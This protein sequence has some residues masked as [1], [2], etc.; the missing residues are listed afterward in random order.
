MESKIREE[1]ERLTRRMEWKQEELDKAVQCFR[2]AAATYSD[3]D[4]ETFIPGKVEEIKRYR[5][6][7][8]EMAEQKQMLE[9][10]L[11]N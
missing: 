3:Y 2:E 1:I 4:I 10:L 7:M 9:Y 5:A 6:A 8:S 11:N